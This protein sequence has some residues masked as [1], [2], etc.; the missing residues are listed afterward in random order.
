MPRAALRKG[1]KMDNVDCAWAWI[2][3]QFKIWQELDLN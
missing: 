1:S 2:S 3:I